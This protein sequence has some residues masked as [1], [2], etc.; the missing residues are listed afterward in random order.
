MPPCKVLRLLNE[1]PAAKS[2]RS[3]GRRS[4]RAGRARGRQPVHRR[5]RRSREGRGRQALQVPFH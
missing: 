5:R 3:M 4:C 2:S 1:V